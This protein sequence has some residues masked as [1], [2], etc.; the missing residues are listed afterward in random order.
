MIEF[1][2]VLLQINRTESEWY[3]KKSYQG[4][5]L[6]ALSLYKSRRRRWK[7]V[8]NTQNY[9]EADPLLLVLCFVLVFSL[10]YLISLSVI[11]S[12]NALAMCI[13]DFLLIEV[14]TYLHFNKGFS[15]C[16]FFK[17]RIRSNLFLFLAFMFLF[18]WKTKPRGNVLFLTA[19]FSSLFVC[20]LGFTNQVKVLFCL[21]CY[22]SLSI[23]LNL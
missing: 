10:I 17:V 5:I 6:N 2:D 23:T 8:I 19:F 13:G 1:H 14:F 11:F 21:L 22:D 20:L 15:V 4:L 16:L 7:K 12:M 3:L 18:R 9:G